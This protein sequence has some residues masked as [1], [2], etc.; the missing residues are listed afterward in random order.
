MK[1]PSALLGS[2]YGL[3]HQQPPL[4]PHQGLALG[5]GAVWH[6]VAAQPAAGSLSGTPAQSSGLSP[7]EM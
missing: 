7:Q 4:C 3:S 1:G 2:I 6:E 5:Q